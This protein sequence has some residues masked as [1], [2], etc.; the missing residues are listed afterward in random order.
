MLEV[1]LHFEQ[2]EGLHSDRQLRPR[3]HRRTQAATVQRSD[4]EEEDLSEVRRRP[5]RI[6]R[7]ESDPELHQDEQQDGC[8]TV[9]LVDLVRH[10]HP[11]SLRV[12]VEKT[13]SLRD[14]EALQEEDV[15]VDV[16]GDDTEETPL[17][18]PVASTSSDP[19]LEQIV[20]HPHSPA[21]PSAV[22]NFRACKE[23]AL[24]SPECDKQKKK[25]NYV[26]HSVLAKVGSSGK[27]KKTVRFAPD[28]A[29]IH[30]YQV[31][32][33]IPDVS[34]SADL[35]DDLRM[36]GCNSQ[37][38]AVSG[39]STKVA[40]KTPSQSD[41][42]KLKT[43]SLQEYRLLRQKTLPKEEKK[44]DYR[45]KWPS[46]SETP[47]GLPPIPCMPGYNSSQVKVQ[48]PSSNTKTPGTVLL[49][50]FPKQKASVRKPVQAVDPPN[51][52]TVSLQPD[53]NIL[54]PLSKEQ[55]VTQKENG[56]SPANPTCLNPPTAVKNADIQKPHTKCSRTISGIGKTNISAPFSPVTV[57]PRQTSQESPP[58]VQIPVSNHSAEE[59]SQDFPGEIGNLSRRV[60]K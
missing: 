51:P 22:H 42:A 52:V 31:E 5:V 2:A 8:A 56:K 46:V 20:P 14:V 38:S 36:P 9:S 47:K 48:T 23:D 40:M 45:T 60:D 6:F 32:G 11:Y 3:L 37:T 57:V 44:M 16:V 25:D 33:D 15:F 39:N 55:K 53:A 30:M 35:T 49:K 27:R 17:G 19:A 7:I 50:S 13:E 10:M 43:L 58:R 18:M 4:G 1:V 26:A 24:C 28:L 59:K 12:A 29:S 41:S 34:S 21:V 54:S